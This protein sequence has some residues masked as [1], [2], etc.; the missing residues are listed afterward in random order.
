MLP[1]F[2]RGPLIYFPVPAPDTEDPAFNVSRLVAVVVIRPFVNVKTP[3]ANCAFA[4]VTPELLFTVILLKVEETEPPIDCAAVPL[5]VT[6]PL[7][8]VNVPLLERSLARFIVPE[9]EIRV[10]PLMVK[11]FNVT[12]LL[13]KLNVPP[14]ALVRFFVLSLIVPP[15]VS[16]PALTVIWRFALKVTAPDNV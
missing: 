13:P 12:A 6:V 2:L 11:P 9:V 15:I 10:P 14:P 7:L 5:K 8:C 16:I 3:S 4:K 1:F